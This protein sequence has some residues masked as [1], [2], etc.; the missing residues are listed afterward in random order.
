MERERDEE[1]DLNRHTGASRIQRS[2]RKRWEL[3]RENERQVDE[4]FG[5]SE[6]TVETLYREREN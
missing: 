3:R 1:G 6:L 2:T 5:P 4:D